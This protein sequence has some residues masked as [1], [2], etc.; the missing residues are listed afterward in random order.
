MDLLQM[1]QQLL[2][3]LFY[4]VPDVQHQFAAFRQM[5]EDGN[6]EAMREAMRR[7]TARRALFDKK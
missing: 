2:R 1:F 3:F 4:V 7:S 6:V 5:L